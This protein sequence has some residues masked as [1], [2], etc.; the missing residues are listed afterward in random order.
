MDNNCFAFLKDDFPDI[1]KYC[2]KAE[3]SFVKHEYVDSINNAGKALEGLTLEIGERE[4]V[5]Y[6]YEGN[7]Y[8]NANLYN[9]IRTLHGSKF[10]S[11][12]EKDLFH[13]IRLSRNKGSH[14]DDNELINPQKSAMCVHEYLYNLTTNF[15]KRYADESFK[16][17][18][19]TGTK[20]IYNVADDVTEK[21]KPYI[22]EKF[23]NINS[24]NQT[25]EIIE[26]LKPL[27]DKKSTSSDNQNEI[28]DEIKDYI[29]EAIKNNSGDI[30]NITNSF[31]TH[32]TS[33]IDIKKTN[34]HLSN[35]EV[36]NSLDINQKE[37]NTN[38][39]LDTTNTVNDTKLDIN[40]T[41][42]DINTKNSLNLEDNRNINNYKELD[43]KSPSKGLYILLACIVILALVVGVAYVMGAFD[44]DS[45]NNSNSIS[46]SD[47]GNVDLSN[48]Y[49]ASVHSGKFHKSN[50]EWAQKIPKD[51]LKT[52]SDRDS[53][54]ADGMIPCDVCNP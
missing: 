41:K 19:Y 14:F 49:R 28:L 35:T 37:I 45:N 10:L 6:D 44:S 24:D 20:Y 9:R 17:P 25:N 16:I 53:A 4:G 27:I 39:D 40:Q 12:D 29:D 13:K 48:P 50:C 52:Y 47:V 31:N 1:Y 32:D 33:N 7:D 42:N 2:Q 54:I 5:K 3:I 36:N 26:K 15:Y 22:D 38:V 23:N 34:A 11:D 43:S 8:I 30:Y 18:K 51:N 21:L 46:S